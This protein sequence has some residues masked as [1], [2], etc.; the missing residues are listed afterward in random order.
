MAPSPSKIPVLNPSR[1]ASPTS[2]QTLFPRSQSPSRIPVS[3]TRRSTLNLIDGDS[4]Y[5]STS[6]IDLASAK[7]ISINELSPPKLV[8]ESLGL[9]NMSLDAL[10]F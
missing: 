2:S 3:P 9:S 10:V 8:G 1:S 6:R 5:V 4:I 7:S